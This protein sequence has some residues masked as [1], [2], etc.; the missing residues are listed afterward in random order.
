MSDAAETPNPPAKSPRPASR[1]RPNRVEQARAK[2]LS[3]AGQV[4]L[5]RH[6]AE[7]A[8]YRDESERLRLETRL[9]DRMQRMLFILMIVWLV[10]MII[11]LWGHAILRTQGHTGLSDNVLIAMLGT[12]TLNVIGLMA[13]VA[14]YLFPS[15]ITTLR[16][17][18]TPNKRR[19][20]A[21]PR[22]SD[23]AV[24]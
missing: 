24:R 7:I 2:A 9:R 14:R 18:G 10:L 15:R 1:K 11:T 8:R 17:P 23:S 19:R 22:R 6:L 4:E 21:A 5:E 13:V 20:Q 16:P 12:T 3:Q